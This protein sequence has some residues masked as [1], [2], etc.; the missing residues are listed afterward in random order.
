[1]T[2][3]F[4]AFGFTIDARRWARAGEAGEVGFGVGAL[5]AMVFGQMMATT[6]RTDDGVLRTTTMLH[7]VA[8][9]VATV[10][11]FDKGERVK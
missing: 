1:M 7:I 6:E 4:E 5:E 3:Q 9:R 10:A 2:Y 8:E 11:L